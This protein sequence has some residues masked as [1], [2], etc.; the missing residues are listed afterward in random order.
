MPGVFNYF[1]NSI[2][3]ESIL[4][5]Q[6]KRTS[7]KCICGVLLLGLAKSIYY[8]YKQMISHFNLHL[9]RYSE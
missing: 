5:S 8:N 9:D 7:K 6:I 4:N 1:N 3:N 2:F